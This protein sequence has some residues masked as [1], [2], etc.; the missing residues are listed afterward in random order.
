M[1]ERS[2]GFLCGRD[3]LAHWPPLEIRYLI[4]S[5]RDC[6][7]RLADHIPACTRADA[8]GFVQLSVGNLYHEI[9]HRY[10]QPIPKRIASDC[11]ARTNRRFSSCKTCTGDFIPTRQALLPAHACPFE[12][13]LR[14]DHYG[15]GTF[16]LVFLLPGTDS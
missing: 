16:R 8:V 13:Y 4:H 10:L 7:G 6:Y 2:C 1:P 15:N 14:G 3:E 5:T 9:L 12:K 11:R